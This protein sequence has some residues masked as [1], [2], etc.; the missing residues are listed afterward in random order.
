VDQA[1]IAGL[2]HIHRIQMHLA[3]AVEV[4]L[5]DRNHQAQIPRHHPPEGPSPTPILARRR[6]GIGPPVLHQSTKVELLRCGQQGNATD[7]AQVVPK[8]I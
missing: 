6:C 3:D 1:E 7:A 2:H 8:A 4:L 5:A